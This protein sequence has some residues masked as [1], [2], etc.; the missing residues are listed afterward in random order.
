MAYEADE[1]ETHISTDDLSEEWVV[2]TRQRSVIS[3]LQK[4][5]Y[6]PINVELEQGRIVSCEFVIPINKI[7][8]RNA[9]SKGRTM[10][11]EQRREAAERMARNRKNRSVCE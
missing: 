10:T 5:G 2:Y 1:R 9:N 6:T 11:D 3:K 8:F 7:S 4:Q